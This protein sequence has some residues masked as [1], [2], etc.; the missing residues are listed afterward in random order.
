M[1]G[2]LAKSVTL[3][4]VYNQE[5]LKKK[6]ADLEQR[7][8]LLNKLRAVAPLLAKQ[9]INQYDDP[10]WDERMATLG[11]AWNWA[12]ASCWIM[13]L[14]D[15]AAYRRLTYSLDASL[16]RIEEILGLLAS[17]KAWQICIERID[18]PQREHLVAWRKA[19]ERVGKGKGK[20]SYVA[21]NRSDARHHMQACRAA[22]PAWIMPI[23]RVAESFVPGK[24]AFDV[25]IVDEASQSGPEALFLQYLAK[26]IIVVGDDK[27]ISPEN[28]GLTKEDVNLLRERNISDLPHSDFLGV[29]H[30]FFELAELR[31]G[32]RIR[33]REH[34]R[35]MPEIIQFSNNLCYASQ[36]LVP[37]RQF[38]AGRLQPVLMTR[39]CGQL[40]Q[41]VDAAR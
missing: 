37:L 24:D 40:S 16:R 33:L 41:M 29:D 12:R 31:Y 39:A 20:A 3:R 4:K 7:A 30:S 13:Q 9:L 36:P 27:Q 6:Q 18:E 32:G 38:G 1:T 22:I 26:Q 34:F 10:Q 28:V 25:V 17:E 5:S 35:C 14:G 8:I 15:P 23:Y 2:K 19:D 11:L 21:K